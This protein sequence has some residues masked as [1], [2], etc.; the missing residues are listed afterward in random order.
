MDAGCALG[1]FP[2]ID[3]YIASFRVYDADDCLPQHGA[4][5]TL[6]VLLIN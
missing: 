1:N 5:K 2:L 4:R 3:N 6:T